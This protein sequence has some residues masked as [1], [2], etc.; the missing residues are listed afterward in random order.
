MRIYSL[1]IVLLLII[2]SCKE[3]KKSS[4]VITPQ[5][6]A[7]IKPIGDQIANDVMTSLKKEL[8]QAIKEGGPVNA[9]GICK[10]EAIPI[11]EIVAASSKNDVEIKRISNKFRNPD[12]APDELESEALK[13]FEQLVA[14]GK[15]I[16][17]FH[18]QKS[19]EEDKII[20]YY[21]KPMKIAQECLICHGNKEEISI[22]TSQILAELYPND[23]A[24]DYKA[25]DFRGLIRVKI[26]EDKQTTD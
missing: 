18:L 22:E 20:F 9:V 2:T 12:N 17:K 26:T 21:Y 3:S 24:T 16:P 5:D 7:L 13:F 19:P 8:M 14:E 4:R 25:G 1:F 10:L 6:I 23:K 15:N 11:G